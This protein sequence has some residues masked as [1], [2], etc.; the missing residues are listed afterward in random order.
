MSSG[1][2]A[3]C[4][5]CRPSATTAMITTVSF[6]ISHRLPGMGGRSIALLDEA[7][8]C[9]RRVIVVRALLRSR[10]QLHFRLVDLLV[11]NRGEQ[12]RYRVQPRRPLVV[13]SDD[14]PRRKARVGR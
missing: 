13:R 1:F 11:R 7:A 9:D 14:V 2:C 3:G 8:A 12:M 4:A 10:W 6:F 5:A